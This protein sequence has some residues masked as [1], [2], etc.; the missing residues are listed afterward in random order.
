MRPHKTHKQMPGKNHPGSFQFTPQIVVQ[1]TRLQMPRQAIPNHG[2]PDA[3]LPP[4]FAD[5]NRLQKRPEVLSLLNNDYTDPQD[6]HNINF[7]SWNIDLNFSWEYRPGSFLTL[8][9]QN[10][11]AN[12]TNKIET[13]FLNNIND[14]FENPS[15]NIFSVKFTYY[16]DI[17]NYSKK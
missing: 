13:L 3:A 4:A 14:L 8:V 17:E 1:Y 15:T 9:W 2:I 6:E 7:N 12:E 10:Q 11:I 5:H 16:L